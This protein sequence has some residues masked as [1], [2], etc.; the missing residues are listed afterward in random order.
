MFGLFKK[1]EGLPN[2]SPSEVAPGTGITYKEDLI[3][4][5]RADHQH[6]FTL[7]KAASDAYKHKDFNE[8]VKQLNKIRHALRVHLLDE[9]LNFYV[10]M[11]HCYSDNEHVLELITSYKR[12]MKKIGQAAFS[13]LKKYSSFDTDI[14]TDDNFLNEFQ[15]LGELLSQRISS[16]EIHLYPLYRQPSKL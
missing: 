3:V 9:E 16:E 12:D 13:F 6:L 14:A 7:Y 1:T 2:A 4:K 10:Y 15:M 11:L 8:V 5:Y